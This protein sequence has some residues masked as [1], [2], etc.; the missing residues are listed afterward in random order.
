METDRGLEVRQ[1]LEALPVEPDRT[2]RIRSATFSLLYSSALK[3][4]YQRFAQDKYPQLIGTKTAEARLSKAAKR[5]TSLRGVIADLSNES[6]LS[7]GDA[8]AMEETLKGFLETLERA[9]Q[10][11]LDGEVPST[12]RG[13]RPKEHPI[14]V[15]KSA[16][17]AFEDLTGKPA[18][19]SNRPSKS[20][21]E[22][23]PIN[24]P[25]A[26]YFELVSGLFKLFKIEANAEHYAI[27]A[28]RRHRAD[29]LRKQ[30]RRP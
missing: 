20:T 7:L 8:Y 21:D 16:L 29:A 1:L 2:G 24:R 26:A 17:H 14:Y 11:L 28:L 22:A 15:A 13:R 23:T 3:G 18:Y 30:N 4:R 10:R 12:Q 19:I 5:I 25:C 6:I 9:R 27:L